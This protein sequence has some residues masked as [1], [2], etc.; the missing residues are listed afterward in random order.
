MAWQKPNV[1][2]L[3]EPTNHLDLE[4]RHALT[5]AL[6]MYEGALVVVSH[7]RHL[8]KN[9]VDQF[10]LVDSAKVEE[11]KGDLRDYETWLLSARN[12]Q[13]LELGAAPA[14]TKIDRRE[15][16][17][18][19]AAKREKLKPLNSSIKKREREIDSLQSKLDDAEQ[20]LAKA[21]LYEEHNKNELKELLQ[22]QADLRT[23][24][25]AA[26]GEW[27]LLNEELEQ[28]ASE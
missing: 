2:L 27:L 8:L 19:A 4:V 28:L 18:Q 6:Q 7:D 13:D 12:D 1:L 5:L 23:K 21:E 14:A 17:Q 24:L 20:R 3:D 25:E 26:E 9:T 22:C 11:F 10:Y 15:Q 16:R